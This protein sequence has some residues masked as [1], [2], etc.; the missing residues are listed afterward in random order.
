ILN[1]CATKGFYVL[2]YKNISEGEHLKTPFNS[3]ATEYTASD[4]TNAFPQTPFYLNKNLF[5]YFSLDPHI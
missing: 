1:L 2:K 4:W 3:F 5:F